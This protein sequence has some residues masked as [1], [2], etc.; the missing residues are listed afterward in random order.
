MKKLAIILILSSTYLLVSAQAFNSSISQIMDPHSNK[1]KSNNQKTIVQFNKQQNSTAEQFVHA[2]KQELLDN[3]KAD[4]IKT[5]TQVSKNG[6]THNS[7]QQTWNGIPIE[8]QYLL[9]HENNSKLESINGSLVQNL[10]LNTVPS[11]SEKQAL[12]NTLNNKSKY[13]WQE[14]QIEQELKTLKKDQTATWFPKGKLVITNKS[15]NPKLKQD[16][17]LAWRFEVYSLQ[18]HDLQI[19]YVNAHSGQVVKSL[20]K[21][22]HTYAQGSGTTNYNGSKTFTCKLHGNHF[23]LENETIET[24]RFSGWLLDTGQPIATLNQ[25][26]WQDKEYAIDVHWGTE[27][28]VDYLDTQLGRDHFDGVGGQITAVTNINGVNNAFW[29]GYFMGF[30]SGDGINMQ[31][32]TSLDIVAHEYTHAMLDHIIPGGGFT[33]AGESGAIEE[34]HCDIFG[35]LLELHVTGS[36]DGIV[37]SKITLTNGVPNSAGIRDL[38]VVRSYKD[39]L[40]HNTPSDNWGVHSNSGLYTYWLHRLITHYNVDVNT[41]T[42]IV[43]ETLFYLSPTS[44]FYDL[45]AASVHVANTNFPSVAAQVD[46]TWVDIGFDGTALPTE[47]TNVH[48]SNGKIIYGGFTDTIF[49]DTNLPIS[50]VN[51]EYSINGGA[52]WNTITTGQDYTIGFYIWEVPQHYSNTAAVRVSDMS[53]FLTRGVSNSFFNLV[54]T[55]NIPPIAEDDVLTTTQGFSID[56]QPWINDLDEVELDTNSM[57]LV[58][59]GVLI[60]TANLLVQDS[61]IRISID[62]GFIGIFSFDY[63]ICD[64]GA[65][66]MCDTATVTVNAEEAPEIHWAMDNHSVQ[67]LTETTAGNLMA[68]DYL[69][70]PSWSFEGWEAIELAHGT[71]TI[72]QLTS[73]FTYTANTTGRDTIRYFISSQDGSIQDTAYLNLFN[74][75]GGDLEKDS[76]F[77][78]IL[79]EMTDGPNWTNPWD[80]N[81]AVDTWS[82]ISLNANRVEAINLNSQNLTGFIPN[83]QLP[84][85]TQLQL[86]LNSI[87]GPIPSFEYLPNLET[88]QLNNNQLS[89]SI[90]NFSLPELINLNLSINNL[91]DTVPDFNQLTDLSLVYL[92]GNQLTG[93]IPLFTIQNVLVLQLSNNNLTDTIP[94][95]DNLIKLNQL[96]LNSNFLTGSIPEFPNNVNL[97]M[98][99]L[100]NNQLSGKIPSINNL[101][102]LI[103]INLSFNQLTDTIPDISDLRDLQGFQARAN[104]LSGPVPSF[105]NLPQLTN[106]VLLE[107]QFT[108]EGIEQNLVISGFQYNPQGLIPTYQIEDSLIVYAG[109]TISD[110]TYIWFNQNDNSSDTIVGQNYYIPT[111]EASY[112][113]LIS[114]EDVTIPTNPKQNLIL[115]SARIAFVPRCNITPTLP[116]TTILCLGDTLTGNPNQLSYQWWRNDTVVGTEQQLAVY[117]EGDYVLEMQDSCQN[118]IVKDTITVT[119][120]PNCIYPGDTNH[121]GIVNHYD[122][123][124]IGLHYGANGPQRSDTSTRFKPIMGGNWLDNTNNGLNIKHVDANGDGNINASDATAVNRNYRKLWKTPDTLTANQLSDI[125]LVPYLIQSAT[126]DSLLISYALESNSGASFQFY[127][128]AFDNY[129]NAPS[130]I[131]G[132]NLGIANNGP[133]PDEF[134]LVTKK[135]TPQL[136]EVGLTKTNLQDNFVLGSE[137]APMTIIVDEEDIGG[138]DSTMIIEISTE[139]ILATTVNSSLNTG[140]FNLRIMGGSTTLYY[141]DSTFAITLSPT[142]SYCDT[143]GSIRIDVVHG[144]GLSYLWE[145]GQTTAVASGLTVGT[146][147]VT[148]V[149]A[150]DTIV[151]T[152]EVVGVDPIT[153][154]STLIPPSPGQNNGQIAIQP[155]GG[156]GQKYDITWSDGQKGTLANGLVECQPYQVLIEDEGACVQSFDYFFEGDSCEKVEVKLFVFLEGAFLTNQNQMSTFLN[157]DSLGNNSNRG[158]L[159]GQ[160]PL[161]SIATP[162]PVGQPYNTY[163]WFYTGTP[164]ENSFG[165]P[166]HP[167]VTDW[168]M[169]SFRTELDPN[170]EFKRATALLHKDG[171]VEFIDSII[172]RMNDIP[173]PE[174]Y[175]SIEHRNHMGIGS[176]AK[177]DFSSGTFTFDFRIQNSYR[178]VTQGGGYIGYGQKEI[179]PGTFVMLAG[180]ANQANSL[181]YDINGTDKIIY[182]TQLG[183][184][185]KYWI[186]GDFSLNGE[187]TGQDNIIFSKNNGFFSVWLK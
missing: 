184:F 165:G 2:K 103:D 51:L 55:Q 10:N 26:N 116:P 53:D 59:S 104:E 58:S 86:H 95:F 27:Q 117:L 163:P 128:I 120:D 63:I 81:T 50:F 141:K 109:D 96:Y 21:M 29:N 17:Q 54:N 31:S 161:S 23:E 30:G 12:Q 139:N 135:V 6:R 70:D 25:N 92:G 72:D 16:Y 66:V 35:E 75:E 37:G 155:T 80:L 88:L 67:N 33:Y 140:N 154:A 142:P 162:T 159:P 132:D 126:T 101:E 136:L 129:I 176:T 145:D 115:K 102:D 168:I 157:L 47:I 71:I 185:D 65:P 147:A 18:P 24:K 7:Y 77:L 124:N 160:T 171:S 127:G 182:S 62:N 166:Y 43:Y 38:T 11:I 64:N 98:L 85:L 108:F 15:T 20:P 22:K 186:N 173:V 131:I 114:N 42:G 111:E 123:L 89:G 45:Y 138:G 52:T 148:V 90:P 82:G 48:P 179:K 73:A 87:V 112:F 60:D 9:T 74:V 99:N 49:W 181:S 83:F 14:P 133:N 130:D 1:T 119:I 122:L 5:N 68:D 93:S 113:C 158:L 144:T 183:L 174:A 69:T 169:V 134:L 76:M 180:D 105:N 46:S 36:A 94:S 152:E 167:D 177:V 84:M 28:M 178:D 97:T 40:W 143:A 110:N 19:I 91:T 170:T 8:G 61:K 153:V 151:A 149:S 156:F 3:P 100:A 78:V 146:Y 79:N 118:P 44:D 172:L 107:N 150:G 121:D 39:A 137:D 34:A 32:A 164:A 125:R 175:V 41:A 106:L 56:I 187:V 57:L 13:A 4:L